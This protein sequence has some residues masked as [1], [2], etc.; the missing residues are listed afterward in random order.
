LRRHLATDGAD[1]GDK[2]RK[3]REPAVSQVAAN[4]G[5]RPVGVFAQLV[6]QSKIVHKFL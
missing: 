4:K 3:M 2:D 1:D 6:Y 5:E